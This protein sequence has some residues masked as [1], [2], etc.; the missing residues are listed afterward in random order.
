MDEARGK[1]CETLVRKKEE[2]KDGGVDDYEGGA[3]IVS[4]THLKRNSE[5]ILASHL[6]DALLERSPIGASTVGVGK[7]AVLDKLL[8]VDL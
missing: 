2:E 7:T 8:H 6:E 1:P 5:T 3:M 4:T